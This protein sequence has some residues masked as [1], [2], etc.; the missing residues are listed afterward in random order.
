MAP[1]H[2]CGITRSRASA[3]STRRQSS[4]WNSSG[5]VRAGSTSAL[6]LAGEAAPERTRLSVIQSNT[7]RDRTLAGCLVRPAPNKQ[8]IAANG[9]MDAQGTAYTLWEASGRSG[10]IKERMDAAT[11][12]FNP[13]LHRPTGA[14]RPAPTTGSPGTRIGRSALAQREAHGIRRRRNQYCATRVGAQNSEPLRSET[15]KEPPQ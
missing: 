15:T 14:S 9:R 1:A 7:S 3:A 8:A 10:I 5:K 4:R 11:S 6:C 13:A 2:Q 12:F